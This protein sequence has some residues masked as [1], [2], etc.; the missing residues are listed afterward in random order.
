M[1]PLYKNAEVE[2]WIDRLEGVIEFAVYGVYD[3]GDP[4][5]CGSVGMALD[6]AGIE[7]DEARAVIA[8]VPPDVLRQTSS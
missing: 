6:V 1:I 5:S 3:S 8:K 4:L 7:G 2:I